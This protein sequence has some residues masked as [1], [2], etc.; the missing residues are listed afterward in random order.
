MAAIMSQQTIK[1]TQMTT[2]T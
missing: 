1:V 2:T